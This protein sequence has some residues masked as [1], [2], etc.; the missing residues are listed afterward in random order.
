MNAESTCANICETSEPPTKVGLK[1]RHT[2]PAICVKAV[3]AKWEKANPQKMKAKAKVRNALRDNRFKKARRLR[4][5]R[6]SRQA[7][8][9]SR[10]L[11]RGDVAMRHLAVCALPQ[12][13]SHGD[14]VTWVESTTVKNAARRTDNDF[15]PMDENGRCP[16]CSYETAFGI[17]YRET[18]EQRQKGIFT[19][20]QLDIIKKLEAESDEG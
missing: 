10:Q 2:D 20:A 14:G 9:P 7:E 1:K 8:R 18:P 12:T 4:V 5:L 19:Q 6:I 16:D 13:H 3:K 11:R 17:S 15:Y